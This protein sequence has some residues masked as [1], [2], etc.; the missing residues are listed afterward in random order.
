M[1]IA[2]IGIDGAG[3]ST[4]AELLAEY[5]NQK[6]ETKRAYVVKAREINGLVLDNI[7]KRMHEK[8]NTS[9]KFIGY[10][11]DLANTFF[12]V[13]KQ[14]DKNDLIIWDRYHYCLE[15]YFLAKCL[16]IEPYRVLFSA[17]SKPEIIF[18]LDMEPGF[19]VN[20]LKSRGGKIKQDENEE[21]LTAVRREYLNSAGLWGARIIN[22]DQTPE[23]VHKTMVSYVS[24]FFGS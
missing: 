4:Q 9:I 1:H 22:A 3:K 21:Y 24:S 7:K 12:E 5:F 15:A 18:L 19:A 14:Y 23:I 8:I 6:E 17:L 13:E 16:D 11:L 20:R 2:I 10:A